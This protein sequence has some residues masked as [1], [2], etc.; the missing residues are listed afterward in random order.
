MARD[1]TASTAIDSSSSSSGSRI[2]SG[3]ESS[4]ECEDAVG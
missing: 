4:A 1:V 2:S 3:G